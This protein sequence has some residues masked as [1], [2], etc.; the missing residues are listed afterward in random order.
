M[1]DIQVG[2]KV[3]I[4]DNPDV[5]GHL[6]EQST[7]SKHLKYFNFEYLKDK[8]GTVI[9]TTG[10]VSGDDEVFVK[11]DNGWTVIIQKR[12]LRLI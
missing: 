5:E 10:I 6:Y 9:P 8:L 12:F 11:L 3:R 1:N 7:P 2:A 4:L